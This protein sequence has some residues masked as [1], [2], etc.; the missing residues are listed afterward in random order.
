[1]V[2]R[3]KYD[4][5]MDLAVPMGDLMARV[6]ASRTD[7]SGGHPSCL[8]PVPLHP[9]KEAVR[10]FNQSMLL[11]CQLGRRLGIPVRPML[12][13]QQ[14]GKPQAALNKNQRLQGL[15]RTFAM[16]PGSWLAGQGPVLLVDDV[17]TTGATLLACAETLK[18]NG[19]QEIC[20]ITF[21]AGC[22][23]AHTDGL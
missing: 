5:A 4:G 10:G 13:R 6:L 1:M 8:I 16:A 11:A 17:I 19:F 14:A 23:K 7:R 2:H 3:L 20:A 21:A 9:A 18:S 12:I 15:G 22:N